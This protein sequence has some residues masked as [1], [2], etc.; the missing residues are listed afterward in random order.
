M[1]LGYFSYPM[2]V[3]ETVLSYGPGSKERQVLKIV[4]E[5]LKNEELDIPMYIGDE[6]VKSG[7]RQPLHPPHEIAHTLGYYYE[8]DE[9]HV[10][11]KAGHSVRSSDRQKKDCG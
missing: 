9:S 8:G 1:S 6:E 10:C 4:L 11:V 5:K 3:N 2:P 7:N